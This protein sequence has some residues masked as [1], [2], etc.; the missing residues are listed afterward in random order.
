MRE[1]MKKAQ[2]LSRP[3]KDNMALF[4]EGD[5]FTSEIMDEVS[6]FPKPL[7]KFQ[8]IAE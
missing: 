6:L 2:E 1:N 7:N 8:R 4:L 3:D 5:I